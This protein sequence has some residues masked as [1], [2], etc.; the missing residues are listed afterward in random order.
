MTASLLKATGDGND[1]AK[2]GEIQLQNDV[3]L[4]ACVQ[5]SR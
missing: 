1:K 5:F 2:S 3:Q 4:G